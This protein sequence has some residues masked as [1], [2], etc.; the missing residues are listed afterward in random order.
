MRVKGVVYGLAGS[1]F[2]VKVWGLWVDG[3]VVSCHVR[4]GGYERVSVG[5]MARRPVVWTSVSV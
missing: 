3:F 2:Y 1:L 5:F 4:L